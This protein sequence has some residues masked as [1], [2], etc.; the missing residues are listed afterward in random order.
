MIV[1]RETILERPEVRDFDEVIVRGDLC[2]AELLIEQ[3]ENESLS[4]EAEP[5]IMRRLDVTVRNRKLIIRFGGSWLERLVDKLAESLTGP[6]M[7]IR[8]QVRELRSLDVVCVGLVR[9]PT[10][11]TASLWIN[12]GGAGQLFIDDLIAQKLVVDQ[13]G[14]GMIKIA[15]RV[16]KQVVR[17]NGVGRYAASRLRTQKTEARLT[18]SSLVQVHARGSLDAVVTGIGRVEY[19]GDPLVRTRVTGTGSVIRVTAS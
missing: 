1:Q 10:I 3:G 19:T 17:S 4:V 16:E 8:L 12:Q 6:N 18:G 2:S 13:S 11:E 7:V 9:A 5:Q 15:G 14:A